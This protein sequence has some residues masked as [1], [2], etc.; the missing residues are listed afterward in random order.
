[1]ARRQGD[2]PVPVDQWLTADEQV[3]A[4]AEATDAVVVMTDRRLFVVTGRRPLLDVPLDGVRRIQFDVEKRRVA[5]LVI[6]PDDPTLEAQVLAIPDSDL[7]STASLLGKVGR[8]LQ[9]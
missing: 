5:T 9:T 2:G 4:T 1:M 6:V 3:E 7:H 8:R